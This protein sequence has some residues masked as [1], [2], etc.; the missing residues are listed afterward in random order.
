[1]LMSRRRWSLEARGLTI[2]Q[3]EWRADGAL[4]IWQRTTGHHDERHFAPRT[5]WTTVDVVVEGEALLATGATLET[6]DMQLHRAGPGPLVRRPGTA[7]VFVAL[8]A[9]RRLDD[10][11][12]A[13]HARDFAAAANDAVSGAAM[14]RL[15][16]RAG[17]DCP[18]DVGRVAG[19]AAAIE[20]YSQR[21]DA[22]PSL[23]DLASALGRPVPRASELAAS[24]FGRFHASSLNW[25]SYLSQLR[26]SLGET[27]ARAGA[28]TSTLS[29]WLGFRSATSFCH[30]RQQRW[31]QPHRGASGWWCSK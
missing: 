20:H 27:G 3:R 31:A 24:Y 16:E 9:P 28:S 26:A 25:R 17:V 30:A 10:A 14:R 21:L 15:L 23:K 12:L 13:R 2:E 5:A 11:T 22:H 19:V 6:G 7:A 18:G 4:V 1:M 29:A 8:R